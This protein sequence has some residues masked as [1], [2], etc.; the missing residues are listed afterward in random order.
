MTETP[1]GEHPL[2]QIT[3]RQTWQAKLD[4]LRVKEKAHTRVGDALAA[5]RRR[6]PMVEVDA[7]TAL[8]GA[9]GPVSLIDIIDGRS[10]LIAY[11][12]MWQSGRASAGQCGGC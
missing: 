9:D 7:R 1:A 4:E 5:E 10:V 3:D 6:L 12:Y 8:I 11:F 2:P